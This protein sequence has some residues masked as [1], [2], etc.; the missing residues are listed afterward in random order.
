LAD[1]RRAVGDPRAA[2]RI[3][4][5]ELHGAIPL[6]ASAENLQKDFFL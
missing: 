6:P 5:H 1:C 3:I 2:F 4:N